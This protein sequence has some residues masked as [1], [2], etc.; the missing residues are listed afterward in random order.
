[1]GEKWV[2]NGRKDKVKNFTAFYSEKTP[3]SYKS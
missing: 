2:K 1:M 3:E